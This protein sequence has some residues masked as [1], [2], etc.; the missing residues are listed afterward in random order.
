MN[1]AQQQSVLEIAK[2][3]DGIEKNIKGIYGYVYGEFNS[4]FGRTTLRE[5]IGNQMQ[6]QINEAIRVLTHRLPS[7]WFLTL[8][9]AIPTLAGML[10]GAFG[11][12]FIR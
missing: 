5:R 2:R 7:K 1:K 12:Y 10:I 3:L 9:V 6:E 4:P 8:E 11:V